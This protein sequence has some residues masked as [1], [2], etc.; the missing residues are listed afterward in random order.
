[1]NTEQITKLVEKAQRGDDAA[2]NE[3]F[4]ETYNDIYYFALKTVKESEL[5]CDIT[6]DTFVA[7]INNL[8]SLK[9]PAAYM[10][11][12]KKIAYSQCTRYFNKKKDVLVD[13]D[14]EGATLF[15]SI[16]EENAEFIPDEALD[17]SEFKKAILGILDTLSPEQRSATMMYYFD[18]MS[19]REISETQNVSEGTVK[20]RLNYARKTIKAGV[21]DY[22]KKNNVK[23]HAIPFFPFFDWLF[24]GEFEG[25][26]P[27]PAAKR[28]AKNIASASGKAISL[29]KGAVAGATV[30]S[31]GASGGAFLASIPLGAKIAAGV[32]A[33]ALLVGG[34][35]AVINRSDK[36]S[37]EESGAYS[38]ESAETSETVSSDDAF[39]E[40]SEEVSQ[41]V[42][43]EE[44]FVDE[45]V[46]ESTDKSTDESTDESQPEDENELEKQAIMKHAEEIASALF[47]MSPFEYVCYEKPNEDKLKQAVL[48]LTEPAKETEYP[49]EYY[50]KVSELEQNALK[51]FGKEMDYKSR[52]SYDPKTDTVID[53]I[54]SS[55]NCTVKA[56]DYTDLGNGKSA[57]K[58]S[59]YDKEKKLLDTATVNLKQSENG[60]SF[61][62][63]V[64]D[65]H[66]YYNNSKILS[67]PN[68]KQDGKL[69]VSC[70]TCGKE[71]NKPYTA[72]AFASSIADTC[73]S[74]YLRSYTIS[75]DYAANV[76]EAEEFL[77]D[78]VYCMV[79]AEKIEEFGEWNKKY[80]YSI[81]SLSEL[82]S[83]LLGKDYDWRSDRRYEAESDSVIYV[84]QGAG[85]G[86]HW[87]DMV[88][89]SVRNDDGNILVYVASE[90]GYDVE[91]HNDLAWLDEFGTFTFKLTE[92]GLQFVSYLPTHKMSSWEIP[93]GVVPTLNNEV[94][95]TRHC[96]DEGCEFNQTRPAYFE[97]KYGTRSGR[98]TISSQ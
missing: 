55:Y 21:E 97:E 40:I 66:H 3:L 12:A 35:V 62:N 61:V 59:V 98:K 7:I 81:E 49:D 29:T 18:E 23:L 91:M 34:A 67:Y 88:L 84:P 45:S 64:N 11:W 51:Y 93:Y 22:E 53:S 19:V 75:A 60:Y 43:E 5:A 31:S 27:I 90:S 41:T 68:A 95:L 25:G 46:D 2:L 58:I 70:N 89:D 80:Y 76:E 57:V 33:L 32:V 8:S 92:K 96:T 13:E 37:G 94:T 20:S 28:V 10:S 52:E 1:M 30:A 48:Y 56:T 24:K 15:D 65:N 44:S 82:T 4:N 86:P 71:T 83:M 73:I 14:E 39:A 74:L 72:E 9:E 50:F 42:S 17:Q 63:I 54:Y 36:E 38:A 16:K 79:D 87:D 85:Y 47:K 26:M 69:L 6:Q 77:I 78:A